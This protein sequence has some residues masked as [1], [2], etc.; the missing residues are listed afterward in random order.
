M[1]QQIHFCTT[2]DGAS[3]AYATI[4]SGPPLI[5]VCGWPGHLA[6]EW[7]QPFVRE[8]LEVFAQRFTLVRYD[9]RGSGLSGGR[10][11]DA[12]ME[13]LTRDLEAVVDDLRQPQVA[14]MSLGLLANPI[15]VT[16]AVDHAERVSRIILLG[17]NLRGSEIATKAQQEALLSYLSAFGQIMTVENVDPRGR[18]LDP[19]LVREAGLIHRE[20]APPNVHGAML[21]LYFAVDL[22]DLAGRVEMPVLVLHGNLDSRVSLARCAEFAATVKDVKFVPYS[23][24]GSSGWA[25]QDA[26]VPEIFRF[27]DAPPPELPV[28]RSAASAVHDEHAAVHTILFTDIADSTGLTQRLGDVKAQELVRAHDAIVRDALAAHG[29][30]ETKHTGDGIMASFHSAS[31]ALECAIDIQRAVAARDVGNHGHAPLQVHVGLNAGEP[32]SEDQ[33]FFGT[34]VQLARRICDHS[35]G[36]EILV[37]DVVRQL[38][39]GKGFLF[40]DRGEAALR[41]FE[42]PVR[43][44]EVRW[45]D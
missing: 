27:L 15:A 45:Q 32:L 40:A 9:M 30:V 14:L 16:Y 2:S 19:D 13:A 39:A 1:E 34:A 17:P 21:K 5:Y 24:S 37:A 26:I 18:G 8:F 41:G 22:T 36:G 35:A 11:D 29:G 44:Y 20:S 23:G 43:V 25:D 10:T 31:G 42:E 38:A 7:E 28:R 3:I 6:L 12:S 4:G 33:D